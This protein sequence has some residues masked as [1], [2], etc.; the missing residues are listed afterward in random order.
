MHLSPPCL[1]WMPPHNP[2]VSSNSP[3]KFVNAGMEHM[4]GPKWMDLFEFVGVS[5]SKPLFYKGNRPFRL[6]SDGLE[7]SGAG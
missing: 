6:V 4:L 5:A 1:D 3:W 2:T 7:W